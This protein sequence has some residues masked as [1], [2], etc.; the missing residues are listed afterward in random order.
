MNLVLFGPPGSGKGTQAERLKSKLALRHISTGDLLRDAVARGTELGNK[1][2][3]ILAAGHLVSDDIVLALMRG[4]IT[5][6]TS[7]AAL[8]GW[9]LDGFPRT[10]GQAEGLDGILGELGQ[11]IDEVIVLDVDREVVIERL[12]GRRTCTKCKTVYHVTVNPTRVEGI[13]DRCGGEVI[14]REDDR[15]ETIARRLDVYEKQTRPI[16]EHYDGRV[17][18]FTI[19]GGQHVDE[20][21]R[22][23]VREL[24]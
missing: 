6:T 15:P 22:L 24:T 4:A 20:V 11:K 8:H 1:V 21:T 17:R 18:I 13:C 7:D 9:I 3:D 19:D 23:I 16:L 12:S 2:K 5:E 10:L 14:Q